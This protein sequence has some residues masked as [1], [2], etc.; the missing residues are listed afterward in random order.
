L[1]GRLGDTVIRQAIM[2]KR[3]EKGEIKPDRA[4]QSIG[5][6]LMTAR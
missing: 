1:R 6:R 2:R 3:R 4:G 5:A